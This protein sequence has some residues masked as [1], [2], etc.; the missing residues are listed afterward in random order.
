MRQRPDAVVLNQKL[1]GGGGLLT[2][3]RLRASIHTAMTPVIAIVGM[4]DGDETELRQHGVDDCVTVPID[5]SAIAEWIQKRLM[6]PT[7]VME[8]PS[9]II[10]DPERLSSLSQTGLLD[11]ARSEPLDALT[12]LAASLLGVPVALV[13]LVDGNRQ[14]FKSYFGLP[15]PWATA[16]E[17]PLSHSFCQW[18]VADHTDL[19]ITDARE[20]PALKHNR[21]LH[22]IGVI[23][24]AGVPMTT[25]SGAAIGSFCAIDTKP[26]TW[27]ADDLHL[28]KSLAVVA[29]A[30]TAL[31]EFEIAAGGLETDAELMSVRRSATVRAAGE[32]MAQ[33]SA[34]FGPGRPEWGSDQREELVAFIGW[35]GQQLVRVAGA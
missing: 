9:S 18:V 29:D 17:T 24:Y 32:A 6:A 7:V 3:R 1:P 27:T 28:L 14:F 23:A 34:I 5:A 20:H 4:R 19:I 30:C 21:A 11:T 13:S 22:E 8:A 35:L 25:S 15:E 2:L 33:L 31:S 12:R 16:R 26:R 10:R